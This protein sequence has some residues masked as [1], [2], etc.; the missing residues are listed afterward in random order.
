MQQIAAMAAAQGISPDQLQAILRVKAEQARLKQKTEESAQAQQPPEAPPAQHQHGPNC[1]HGHSHGQEVSIQQPNAAS[2]E[3]LALASWLRNQDLK[4]RTCI[5][6]GQRKDLF[7][8]KRALRVLQ[9]PVY[10]KASAK[11]KILPEV[12]D[13]KT[14]TEAFRLLPLSVLALRVSKIEPEEKPKKRIKG[15]WTV[16]IERNQ[17]IRDELHYVWLY[18]GRQIK[19][20]LYAVGAL[21]LIFG[22]VLFPLWPYSLRLGVYYLSVGIAGLIGLFFAMAIFRLM[23]FGVTFFVLPPGFWVSPSLP[24]LDSMPLDTVHNLT[25]TAVPESVRGRW[26]LGLI[27]ALVGMA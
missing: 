15:L 6:N 19:Q 11:N 20:K 8:V 1:Q 2:A 16:Q 26:V 10:A 5:L 21:V 18:E 27:P 22:V 7:K 17:E 24:L 9:S 14:A 4:T 12:T 25:V 3:A 13:L 23:L